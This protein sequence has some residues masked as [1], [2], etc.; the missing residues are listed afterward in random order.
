LA[1]KVPVLRS[2]WYP[3]LSLA[4]VPILETFSWP[5]EWL[6]EIIQLTYRHGPRYR[7]FEDRLHAA[8]RSSIGGVGFGEDGKLIKIDKERFTDAVTLLRN[9]VNR[10]QNGFAAADARRFLASKVAQDILQR[11]AQH[12]T[13]GKAIQQLQLKLEIAERVWGDFHLSRRADI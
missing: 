9:G 1:L 5:L 6:L 11:H 2:S 8:A 12:T 13:R 3:V 4:E 10:I 7:S